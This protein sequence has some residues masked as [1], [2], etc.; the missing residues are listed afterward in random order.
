MPFLVWILLCRIN[1]FYCGMQTFL[2]QNKKIIDRDGVKT[3]RNTRKILTFFAATSAYA[4]FFASIRFDKKKIL[5]TFLCLLLY[6]FFQCASV[7]SMAA[8]F[9]KKNFFSLFLFFFFFL[10]RWKRV[11]K[12]WK[13]IAGRLILL[14]AFNGTICEIMSRFG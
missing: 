5:R 7:R 9:P 8:R 3:E 14:N 4:C 2:P 12:V 1:S 6:I 13:F 10:C 11:K